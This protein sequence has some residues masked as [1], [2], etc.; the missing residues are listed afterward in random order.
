[1]RGAFICLEG[2]DHSGKTTQCERLCEFLRKRHADC[3]IV[4]F[5]DRQTHT[6][7][8]ID[9]Y[10]AEKTEIDDRAIHLLYAANRWERR[11]KLEDSLRAGTTLIVDR[12]SFSGVAYS[13]AKCLDAA[14]CKASEVGLPCP[15]VVVY[16]QIGAEDASRRGTQKSKE[17]YETVEFQQKVAA[18]YESLFHRG[19][20]AWKIVPSAGPLEAIDAAVQDIALDTIETCY[21][22]PIR[23][24]VW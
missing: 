6:G 7:R 15:D 16:L 17:R 19:G 22:S 8:L 11:Q 9:A 24:I 4:R 21:R 18:V 13:A 10:L 12:Y 20:A 3:E 5:P 23:T 1:M 2:I 14:W